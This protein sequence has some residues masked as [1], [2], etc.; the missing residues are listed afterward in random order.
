MKTCLRKTWKS[1]QKLRK[2]KKKKKTKSSMKIYK[3]PEPKNQCVKL[4]GGRERNNSK[5]KKDF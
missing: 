2:N 5:D 3:P 4:Q 1:K